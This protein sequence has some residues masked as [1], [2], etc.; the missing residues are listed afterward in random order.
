MQHILDFQQDLMNARSPQAQWALAQSAFLNLGVDWITAGT[1]P[2]IALDAITVRTNLP[3]PIMQDYIAARL[4]QRDQWIRDSARG[5][6][7]GV[8]D[9]NQ[10]APFQTTGHYGDLRDVFSAYG[11]RKAHLLPIYGG[12][13]P[14]A[15]VL[16][17]KGHE[18]SSQF[19]IPERLHILSLMSAVLSA[20]WRPEHLQDGAV[21]IGA[22]AYEFK[23]V[24]SPREREA[25][26][27]LAR[28]LHTLNIADRM[29]IEAVTAS[30]HLAT[31]RQKLGARTREQALALAIKYN[32]IAP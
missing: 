12:A 28:G 22:G 20:H 4:P 27:W 26:L 6:D 11:I 16:Y 1:A 5:L 15:I 25:L 2:M 17:A 14:G 18:E 19:L 8:L 30:K 23:T 29:G 21:A 10:P 24:L 3:S 32:L 7:P 31:A 13:R 9:I